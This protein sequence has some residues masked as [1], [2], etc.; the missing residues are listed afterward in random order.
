[1]TRLKADTAATVSLQ[2]LL[3]GANRI[4]H[5]KERAI[6][7][8]PGIYYESLANAA[9]SINADNVKTSNELYQFRVYSDNYEDI[10]YRLRVLLDG[11]V[12][13]DQTLVGNI[14][15]IWDGDGP[16]LFDDSME[17]KVKT[18]QF[19]IFM[20]PKAAASV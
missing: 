6:P 7:S 16:D 2:A 10:L 19:R 4:W 8:A 18:T 11:Y 15:S 5:G 20:V 3:G 9:A 12:F 13:P 1:M 17:L 14:Y